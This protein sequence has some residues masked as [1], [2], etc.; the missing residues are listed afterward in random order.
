MI[1][2]RV[3][4]ALLAGLA[5]AGLSSSG[6]AALQVARSPSKA[7]LLGRDNVEQAFQYIKLSGKKY[8]NSRLIQIAGKFESLQEQP[9]ALGKVKDLVQH[10]I[11][12]AL[13]EQSKD[14][15]RNSFCKT[16]MAKSGE[17]LK[18]LSKDVE[19]GQADADLREAKMGELK[20][21]VTDLHDSLADLEKK[22]LDEANKRS[23]DQKDYEA[24]K[25][26]FDNADRHGAALR[27]AERTEEQR[28]LEAAA[29]KKRIESEQKERDS[30][31][32]YKSFQEAQFEKKAK[33]SGEIKNSES[34]LIFMNRGL[35]EAKRDLDT[36][37]Q[38]LEAAQDYAEKLKRDCTVGTNPDVERKQRREQ[39]IDSLKEAHQILTGQA[40]PVDLN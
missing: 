38:E 16:E 33:E 40:I 25:E 39:E 4:A 22:N 17:K 5:L 15:S 30:A 19:K 23:S 18:R 32:E 2:M 37:K 34:D 21:K 3:V 10:M 35:F 24:Q 14:T 20:E 36:T 7:D 28:E 8:H 12:R 11:V 1:I 29:I 31:Y 27:G 9:D 26:Q 6:V 13:T